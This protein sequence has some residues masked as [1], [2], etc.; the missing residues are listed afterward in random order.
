M[1]KKQHSFD[2]VRRVLS[3]LGN[4]HDKLKYIHITGT[5]GK[6]SVAHMC[7]LALTGAGVK[8]GLF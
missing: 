4:P 5:N 7:A 6:G 3:Q 2:G 1:L 8:A